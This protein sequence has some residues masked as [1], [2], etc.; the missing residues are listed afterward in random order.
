MGSSVYFL[1]H[2]ISIILLLGNF[3]FSLRKVILLQQLWDI[4]VVK[5]M[6]GLSPGQ[7]TGLETCQFMEARVATE[8][9]YVKFLKN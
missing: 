2:K 6:M 4:Q 8:R 5:M 9:W 7:N 1:N 3:Y